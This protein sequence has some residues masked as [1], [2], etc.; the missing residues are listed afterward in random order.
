MQR[1]ANQR[2]IVSNCVVYAPKRRPQK[3]R[4]FLV[5]VTGLSYIRLRRAK[6]AAQ[7]KLAIASKIACGQL[8]ANII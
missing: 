6:F 3:G 2:C 1:A 8:R 4:L 5:P 7:A